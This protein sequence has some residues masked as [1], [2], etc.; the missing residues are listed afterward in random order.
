MTDAA[1]SPNQVCAETRPAMKKDASL[2][3]NQLSPVVSVNIS[4]Y[5]A[6]MFVCESSTKKK[7]RKRC[8]NREP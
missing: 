8:V 6:T 2:W 3:F 7:K 4:T 1:F 5:D